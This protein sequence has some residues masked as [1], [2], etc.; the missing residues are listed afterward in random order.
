LTDKAKTELG[1]ALKFVGLSWVHAQLL[2]RPS[3]RP[4][5]FEDVAS[6]VSSVQQQ[7]RARI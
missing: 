3:L 4:D 7:L 1:V 2:L 6:Q 5:M